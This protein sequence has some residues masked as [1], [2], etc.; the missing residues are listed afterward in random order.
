MYG[1]KLFVS[2]KLGDNDI[3]YCAITS[4]LCTFPNRNHGKYYPK[5]N[6]PD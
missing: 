4:V 6:Y 2:D 1:R 5:N 3:E